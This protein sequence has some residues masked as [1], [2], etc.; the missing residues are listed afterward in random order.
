ML[1]GFDSVAFGMFC[2]CSVF[3]FGYFW[4]LFIWVR[5]FEEFEKRIVALEK[6]S[7]AIHDGLGIVNAQMEKM[8]KAKIVGRWE[9]D[10]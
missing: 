6:D 7:K 5:R 3:I 4:Y 2:L 1:S 9:F 10:S 8:N